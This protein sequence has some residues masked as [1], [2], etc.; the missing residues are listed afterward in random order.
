MIR[1]ELVGLDDV[2]GRLGRLSEPLTPLATRVR[3]L[4]HAQHERR[5]ATEKTDPDGRAWPPLAASTLRRKRGSM[6]VETGRLLGSLTSRQS[7]LTVTEGN[8]AAPYNVFINAGTRKMPARRYMGIGAD[9]QREIT[10]A[11]V[12]LIRRRLG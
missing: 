11:C 12:Q 8:Q 1:W 10:D 4:L 6:L 2:V 3:V 5:I 9:G 7:G